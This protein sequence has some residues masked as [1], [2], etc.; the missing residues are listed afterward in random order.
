MKKS[1]YRNTYH[2][3]VTEA[4]LEKIKQILNKQGYYDTNTVEQIKYEEKDNLSYYILN[5]DSTKYIGQGAYAMLDGIF[6]E[7]NSIIRQ[8]EG[9]FY[10]PIMIIRKVTSENL[11]PY[12]NPDM[13]KIHEL[14]HLQYI[15]DHINKNPDYIEE[16]RIYNAGSCS[17]A[18]I[19]K[20][21][22]FELTKLFFN[23][24]PAFVADFE[25]GERDYYLYSDG[26]ASV[27]ASDNK[28]EYVQYN[29]AQYI[30]KLRAAYISR[31][32]DKT[33]EI[34]DY[35]ADEVN[36]QGKEIFGYINTMEKLAIVLFKFMFLAE[37]Y[38]KHFKLE[39]CHI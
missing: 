34:S 9:I 37:R 28:D 1:D 30:A 7:I 2:R 10:L 19:K 22:K 29:L 31:F 14:I 23:E 24:L 4:N 17:Y 36:K 32:P 16:A 39:E 18:D 3:L 12:I 5:V 6:V 13:H 11:K 26:M 15:I 27:A 21:I 33:K 35:I 8:W 20:S 25:N 38:G